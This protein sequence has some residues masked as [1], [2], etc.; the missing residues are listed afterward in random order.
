MLLE[1]RFVEIS[2]AQRDCGFTA[3]NGVFG[4]VSVA[5]LF[6]ERKRKR[7]E[8]RGFGAIRVVGRRRF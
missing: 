3:L 7:P 5:L 6:G 2:F 1:R 8:T 4:P